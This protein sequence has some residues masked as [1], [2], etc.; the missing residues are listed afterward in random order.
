MVETD[1][2]NKSVLGR[3]DTGQSKRPPIRGPVEL[4]RG[5]G[6]L[7]SSRNTTELVVLVTL[8][9]LPSSHT[10]LAGLSRSRR[11]RGAESRC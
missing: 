2:E 10:G 8:E 9:C 7:R 5:A 11:S 6:T 1:Y 4:A 3:G